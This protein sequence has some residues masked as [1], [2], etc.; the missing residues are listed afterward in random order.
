MIEPHKPPPSVAT[1]TKTIPKPKKRATLASVSTLPRKRT[2]LERFAAIVVQ[3]PT[4]I[5]STSTSSPVELASTQSTPIAA[6]II[7]S[8]TITTS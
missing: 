6:T 4:V 2:R 5:S 1:I 3:S 7:P 8:L